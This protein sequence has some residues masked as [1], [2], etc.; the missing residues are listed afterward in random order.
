MIVFLTTKRNFHW[1]DNF[2]LGPEDLVELI[3]AL[4]FDYAVSEVICGGEF[5]DGLG[6]HP[7]L[8]C[9]VCCLRLQ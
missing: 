3:D 8:T 9:S 1:T 7:K 2:N 5:M 6:R 4:V